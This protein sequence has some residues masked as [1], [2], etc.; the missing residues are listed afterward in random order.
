M[1][2][3]FIKIGNDWK[4]VNE[5]RELVIKKEDIKEEGNCY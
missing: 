1:C 5:K 2:F 3:N 4:E